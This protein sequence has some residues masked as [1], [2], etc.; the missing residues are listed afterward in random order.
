VVAQLSGDAK[1]KADS[2]MAL[3]TAKVDESTFRREAMVI[4]LALIT[5]CIAFLVVIKRRLDR[6][7]EG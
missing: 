5:A 1:T 6:E 7:L 2:A 3:A 4:V